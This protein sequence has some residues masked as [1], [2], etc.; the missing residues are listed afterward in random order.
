MRKPYMI[1]GNQKNMSDLTQYHAR[2]INGEDGQPRRWEIIDP[3]GV[4]MA[5]CESEL[6]AREIVS[7]LIKKGKK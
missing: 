7:A 2:R 5:V 1:K 3:A 4:R 6:Y